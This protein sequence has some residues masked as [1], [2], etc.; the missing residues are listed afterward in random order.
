MIDDAAFGA[1]VSDHWLR[2]FLAVVDGGS[3]TAAGRALGIGQPA[4]SHAIK[5][6]EAALG[7][8]V[9]SREGGWTSPT[10]AG[11]RLYEGARSG[12]GTVDR[13]V[14]G[15][16]AQ[17][18][19]NEVELAVSTP[20][21]A[22]WLMPQLGEFRLLHPEIDLRIRTGDSDRLIGLDDADLWIPLG[23]GPW[24][25]MSETFFHEE[26]IYPVAAPDHELARPE[27]TNDDLLGADLLVHTEQYRA[28]FNWGRWF[29]HHELP[30]P[31]RVDALQFSDYSLVVHAALVGQG[32]ALGWH[33]IVR[34]LIDEGRLARVGSL[35]IRTSAPFVILTRP[36]AEAR[37]AVRTLRDWLARTAAQESPDPSTRL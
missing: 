32:V 37:S 8:A 9:V 13:S 35:E 5:Q 36:R 19:E 15:A 14:R 11:R 4:V 33:H 24:P 29:A 3:F 28:R 34:R 25:E 27:T 10:E 26:R 2:V 31:G 1:K 17:R 23:R 20:L 30:D 7:A 22:Y 12:F 16:R 21:A 18:R 6:L